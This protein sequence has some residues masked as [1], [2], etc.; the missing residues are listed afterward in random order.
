M[1]LNPTHDRLVV[2]T[3]TEA[4]TSA[5]GVI[6]PETHQTSTRRGQ[7]R[8]C[9]PGRTNKQG[10]L[11]PM[12]LQVGDEVLFGAHA[13]QRIR[14]DGHELTVLNQDDVLALVDTEEQK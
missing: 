3:I 13:G 2:E 8:A 12:T 11:I 5:A 7:V 14:I 10:Q 6:L 1:L 9:G 4:A